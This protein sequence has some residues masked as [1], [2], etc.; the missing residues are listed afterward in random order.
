[1]LAD[2]IASANLLRTLGAGCLRANRR[3]TCACRVDLSGN[4]LPHASGELVGLAAALNHALVLEELYIGR[5]LA[6]W[7]SIA[8]SLRRSMTTDMPVLPRLMASTG[9]A[10]SKL[11]LLDLASMPIGCGGA[12]SWGMRFEVSACRS[13]RVLSLVRAVMVRGR[14]KVLDVRCTELSC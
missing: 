6:A 5:V 9:P 4:R 2:T 10:A 13:D 7:P 14:L 8:H 1:M 12:H 3:L 11:R